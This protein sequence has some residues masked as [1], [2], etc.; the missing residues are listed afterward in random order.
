MTRKHIVEKFEE[1]KDKKKLRIKKDTT[2]TQP[3]TLEERIAELEKRVR[4][5]EKLLLLKE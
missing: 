3:A 1:S 5:L 4:R 2:Q